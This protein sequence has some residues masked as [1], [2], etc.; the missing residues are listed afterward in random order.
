MSN[1][2]VT[3]IHGHDLNDGNQKRNSTAGY[4]YEVDINI[5]KVD[6]PEKPNILFV[7]LMSS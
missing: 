5:L 3:N 2:N 4:N 1:N 6:V 7:T